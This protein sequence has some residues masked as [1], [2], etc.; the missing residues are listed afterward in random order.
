[1]IMIYVKWE[2]YIHVP[3]E[4][5][6]LFHSC[7]SDV[8]LELGR[9][10][11]GSFYCSHLWT[12]YKRSSFSKIRVAYNFYR[13]ILHVPGRSSASA[14][15]VE[16]NIPNFECLIRRIANKL[17]I[18]NYSFISRLKT[19]SNMLISALEFCY[20]KACAL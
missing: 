11:C 17:E 20:L 3:I 1:M 15:F 7:S 13:K 16:N 2:Y 19:S 6:R 4:L 18:A 14:M 12:R 9:S 10:F 8:L 5:L